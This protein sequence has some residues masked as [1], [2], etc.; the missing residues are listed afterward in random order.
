MSVADVFRAAKYLLRTPDL[1]VTSAHDLREDKHCMLT[2]I[3]TQQTSKW[4]DK[5]DAELMLRRFLRRDPRYVGSIANF[6][7][8][9]ATH[10]EILQIF[11]KL[12]E[13]SEN[14]KT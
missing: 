9:H 5:E 13:M 11:D 14:E 8:H 1:W 6:N 4:K 2:A 3:M 12:I 10:R 7:D